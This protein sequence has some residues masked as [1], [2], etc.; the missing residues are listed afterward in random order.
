M[1]RPEQVAIDL[2]QRSQVMHIHIERGNRSPQSSDGART[3]EAV[4]L[5]CIPSREHL[6]ALEVFCHP[7]AELS[8]SRYIQVQAC[9]N[10]RRLPT[11][12]VPLLLRPG[13]AQRVAMNAIEDE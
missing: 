11:H 4:D 9:Q 6:V 5:R 2:V 13:L 12:R 1:V 3:F 8:V 10:P 7:D